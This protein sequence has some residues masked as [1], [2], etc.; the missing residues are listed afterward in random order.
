LQNLITVELKY[1]NCTSDIKVEKLTIT[2]NFA[3]VYSIQ[4][5]KTKIFPHVEND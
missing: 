3:P 2:L 4:S 1:L 5:L